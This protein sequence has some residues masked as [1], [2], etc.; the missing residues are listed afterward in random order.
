MKR[1][2]AQPL[3]RLGV[4]LAM[5]VAVPAVI[6][7]LIWALPGDPASII[8]PPEICGGT[9]GLAARWNLD[10]GPVHF[11]Q[12]WMGGAVHGDLGNS[13]RVQQGVPIRSLVDEAVPNTVTLIL[14]AMIPLFAAS[15]AAAAGWLP[16]KLDAAW[17]AVGL[18]PAVVL[19]LVGAAVVQLEFGADMYSDTARLV[20]LL[21][22]AAVLGV[23]DGALSGAVTGTRGLFDRERKQRYVQVAELRGERVLSNTLPNAAGA[24][25]GQMRARILHLLSGA[26]VVEAVLRIDG[27]GDLL[28]RATLL[29]DFGLVLATATGFALLS[30]V[31]LFVQ[32]L[33]EIFV[34]W[35]IRRAPGVLEVA[36]VARPA[37][38]P[39]R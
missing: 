29:Q 13:W 26:V 36:P 3:V 33:L 16:R 27:L 18:V 15:A 8:C 2:W 4:A 30:G 38:E 35:H 31:L 23:A 25:V 20:R 19:A 22:G 17:Q 37:E 10:G 7:L 34:A 24:L 39:S 28:W 1:W 21:A 9:E 14:L 12:A 11:Y 5:P 32:A 6:T